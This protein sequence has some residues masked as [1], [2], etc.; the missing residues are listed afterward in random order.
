MFKNL[1]DQIEN[2]AYT[3]NNS[4]NIKKA[5]NLFDEMNLHDISL[6][7]IA[8]KIGISN[9]YLSTN[10][11]KEIGISFTSYILKLK[12]NKAMLLL[13]SG[14]TNIKEVI[15]E[16]GFNDYNYSFKLFK[17]SVGMTPKEYMQKYSN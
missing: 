8:D 2:K 16:S 11:K 7:W 13:E 6:E 12:L 9:S 4:E 17:K 14:T 15:N 5:L 3:K 1:I 10:F